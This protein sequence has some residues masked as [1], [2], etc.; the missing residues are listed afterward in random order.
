MNIGRFYPF[1][2]YSKGTGG[3]TGEALDPASVLPLLNGQPL[4][5]T[6]IGRGPENLRQRTETVRDVLADVLYLLDADRSGLCLAGPGLVSWG[7]STTTA[8]TGI[9]ALSGNLY[10]TPF[11]TPGFAQTPPIPPV[12]SAYGTLT[13]KKADGN[14]GII[15]TSA[16][17][18]YYLGNAINVTVVAGSSYS[19]EIVDDYRS[20][21]ITATSTTTLSQ[22]V[23]DLSGLVAGAPVSGPVVTA[24]LAGGAI[25]ADLILR[26]QLKQYVLGNVDAEAHTLTAANFTSF[27]ATVGNRLAEGDSLCITYAANTY[28]PTDPVPLGGRRQSIPE[29]SNTTVPVGSLFNSRVQ[30]ALL[31]NAL[32][33]CK[34][35]NNR[36]VFVNGAQVAAGATGYALGNYAVLDAVNTFLKKMVLAETSELDADVAIDLPAVPASGY[37]P[38]MRGPIGSG[39]RSRLFATPGGLSL[40]SNAIWDPVAEEWS[41][42]NSG[43]GACKISIYPDGCGVQ[44]KADSSGDWD[45]NSWDSD[46]FYVENGRT[47][48][49]S[50]VALNG[51]VGGTGLAPMIGIAG[52]RFCM[53]TTGANAI[54]IEQFGLSIGNSL[55]NTPTAGIDL[56]T[57][58]TGLTANTLYYLYAYLSSGVITIDVSTTAPDPLTGYRTK[59]GAATR[60][61][62]G[63]I[64]TTPNSQIKAF[65]RNGR[66]TR[67]LHQIAQTDVNAPNYGQIGS[68]NATGGTATISATGY[69]PP[70]VSKADI[71]ALRVPAS[72]GGSCSIAASTG[73]SLANA[74]TYTFTT[75]N[76]TNN[77]MFG[78]FFMELGSSRNFIAAVAGSDA[79]NLARFF[80]DGYDD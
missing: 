30:P 39:S 66:R 80:V 50:E 60:T 31:T 14:P 61:Y 55:V 15:V 44:T 56:T 77:N 46:P 26:P 22:V 78:P 28:N 47:T 49:P 21:I 71:L 59:T 40:V 73:F 12:A 48:F 41:L 6:N 27:F 72:E 74:S 2:D 62:L 1:V 10:L 51:A 52:G 69:I 70:W 45:D 42:E 67:F 13:L 38:V 68:A 35:V 36:L 29:N 5:H 58:I 57:T 53:Y 11:L 17:R 19:I 76:D 20:I 25:G 24:A 4:D 37:R 18:S 23:S 32:P 34:V 65:Y 54:H 16:I 43:A 3:D 75:P 33:I 63:C 8:G 64:R 79:G 7:G 9:V